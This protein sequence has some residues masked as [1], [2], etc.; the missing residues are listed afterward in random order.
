MKFTI[1]TI[2]LLFLCNVIFSQEVGSKYQ[3]GI[4]V[5]PGI[6]LNPSKD[7]INPKFSSNLFTYEE[8][9]IKCKSLNTNGYN[10]WQVPTI[11]DLQ[12]IHRYAEDNREW[13]GYPSP[14]TPGFDYISSSTKKSDDWFQQKRYRYFYNMLSNVKKLNASQM[15]LRPLDYKG[16]LIAVR[17]FR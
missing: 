4:V 6:I 7:Y 5:A 12:N 10:D 8:A 9:V 17:Y 14:I 3:G 15:E 1:S 11:V 13:G 16:K 2:I